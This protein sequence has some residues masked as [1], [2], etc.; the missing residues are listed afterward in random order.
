MSTVFRQKAI[1][2]SAVHARAELYKHDFETV[3]KGGKPHSYRLATL[4]PKW[5]NNIRI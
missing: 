2:H 5:Q 1:L 3:W 4:F